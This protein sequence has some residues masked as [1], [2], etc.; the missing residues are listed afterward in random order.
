MPFET[1]LRVRLS[2]TDFTGI[3]HHSSYLLYF[4]EARTSAFREI[5][6]LYEDLDKFGCMIAVTSASQNYKLPAFYDD[7]L[8]ILTWLRKINSFVAVFDYS[9]RRGADEIATGNTQ[10]IFLSKAR[11]HTP[12]RVPA[13]ILDQAKKIVEPSS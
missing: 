13:H 11:P 10:I 9:V 12:F 8:S 6:L 1:S 5:G 3:V 2:E 4:E 7:F